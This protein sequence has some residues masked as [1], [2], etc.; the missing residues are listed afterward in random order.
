MKLIKGLYLGI[1]A[2]GL[3]F[4]NYPNTVIASTA[5]DAPGWLMGNWNC[6][7]DGRPAVM[8]W[9][10]ESITRSCG[11]NCTSQG[12]VTIGYFIDRR[13]KLARKLSVKG[14]SNKFVNILVSQESYLSTLTFD[15][16]TGVIRSDTFQL[17]GA[18]D[19]LQCVK[20]PKSPPVVK[21]SVPST[22]P[23]VE[24]TP[25]SSTPVPPPVVK[26]QKPFVDAVEANPSTFT[27]WCKGR[28]YYTKATQLTID[29]LLEKAGTNDCQQANSKLRKLRKLD[30]SGNKIS[31]LK[32]LSVFTNL[33]DIDLSRN[34]ISDLQPLAKL[35]ELNT[36]SLH[37]NQIGSLSSLRMINR[38]AWL[39]L[40]N[41]Q[42]RSIEPL[43]N[44]QMLTVLYIANNKISDLKLFSNE[45]NFRDLGS[46]DLSYNQIEDLNPLALGGKKLTT[47]DLSHNRIVNVKPLT[48]LTEL[49]YLTLSNNQIS[50]LQPLS[51]LMNLKV[52]KISDKEKSLMKSCPR[53][54]NPICR[55][56]TYL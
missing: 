18:T 44:L 40:S 53:K 50:D 11:D 15:E 55:Y 10:T 4:A 14:F 23:P 22:P 9:K 33:A 52:I 32:P 34:R 21:P 56:V 37:T 28:G 42:I 3:V 43:K 36:L 19:L 48:S 8:R 29:V 17:G 27:N 38:L 39:D 16:S 41:N 20:S 49:K 46:L 31:D 1:T 2:V 45:A 35:K 51:S 26:P 12:A 6:N 24:K 13:N 5:A 7:L 47:L 54:P 25:E 30:L